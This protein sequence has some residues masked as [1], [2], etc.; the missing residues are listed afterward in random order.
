MQGFRNATHHR[1]RFLPLTLIAL[2]IPRVVQLLK[3]ARYQS[4]YR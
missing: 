2:E 3:R 4:L 1:H